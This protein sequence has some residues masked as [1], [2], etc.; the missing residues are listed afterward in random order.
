[1]I[2]LEGPDGAGKS[3]LLENL[4]K[5]GRS[6]KDR[7]HYQK[8]S[9]QVMFND[10]VTAPIRAIRDRMH[11]SEKVYGTVIRGADDI[12]D[13]YRIL[14]RNLLSRK[15]I[16]VICLPGFDQ[17]LKVWKSRI[18]EEFVKDSTKL[19]H[20]YDMYSSLRTHLPYI[21]YNWKTTSVKVLEQQ[22]LRMMDEEPVNKGPGIGSFKKG[23]ILL[24]GDKV[25][26]VDQH[27]RPF[28]WDKGSAPWFATQLEKRHI[29]ER[30][31][32]WA[33]S[34]TYT[35]LEIKSSYI[36]LLKPSHIFALGIKAAAYCKKNGL[37]YLQY[38]H[39]QYWKRFKHREEYPLAIH[40]ELLTQEK[41]NADFKAY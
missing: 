9:F 33:N 38:P 14:E 18:D 29:P 6:Y 24:I 4:F 2:I 5:N 39:P 11:P 37:E 20:I 8:E 41:I 21:R 34:S 27:E 32:Y 1:M 23:N 10:I 17:C 16:L 3:Y 22:I 12:G 36:N 30:F 15:S 26:R 13:N 7:K 28:S 19:G 31:L 25:P 40:L 35:G